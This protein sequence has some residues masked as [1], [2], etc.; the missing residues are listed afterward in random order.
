MKLLNAL[1]ADK[2]GFVIQNHRDFTTSADVVMKAS[3]LRLEAIRAIA[4]EKG[5]EIEDTACRCI[6]EELLADFAEAH[7]RRLTHIARGSL[8]YPL[9]F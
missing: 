7:V 4:R 1:F 3:G 6:D 5:V 9:I 8:W 2:D